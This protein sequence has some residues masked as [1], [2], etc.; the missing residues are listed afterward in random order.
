VFEIYTVIPTTA[1]L[2][3]RKIDVK[4][5]EAN[6]WGFPRQSHVGSSFHFTMRWNLECNRSNQTAPHFARLIFVPAWNENTSQF[7]VKSYSRRSRIILTNEGY[8]HNKAFLFFAYNKKKRHKIWKK[9]RSSLHL[10]SQEKRDRKMYISGGCADKLART[11]DEETLVEIGT[12][13]ETAARNGST[14]IVR[15]LLE[16]S[17]GACVA[18]VV[19]PKRRRSVLAS[20][21][22]L[23]PLSCFHAAARRMHRVSPIELAYD[24]ES[25]NVVSSHRRIAISPRVGIEAEIKETPLFYYSTTLPTLRWRFIDFLL[26]HD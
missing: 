26:S 16:R 20:L 22:L 19:D 6:P 2:F 10:R 9:T 17:T 7:T 11:N 23:F 1:T 13:R 5:D 4:A 25:F 24:D 3:I 21:P 8:S 12:V 15:F 18:T 14:S